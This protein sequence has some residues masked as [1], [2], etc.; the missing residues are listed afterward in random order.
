MNKEKKITV[1]SSPDCMYCYTVKGYLE[2]NGFEYEE[3]NIYDD[4]EAYERM[5]EFS[6][7]KNVPVTVI[8]DEV[9]TGWDK[10]KFK[11]VLGI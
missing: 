1:Y 10:E 3:I 2:D 11:K 6:G 4:T 7:Q 5:K 8:G 9:I